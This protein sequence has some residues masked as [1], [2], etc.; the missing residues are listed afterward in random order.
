MHLLVNLAG[1][2]YHVLLLTNM[3]IYNFLS[4]TGGS[5]QMVEEINIMEITAGKIQEA[6][7]IIN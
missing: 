1:L 3:S 6:N 5:L 2:L 7:Q 4:Q